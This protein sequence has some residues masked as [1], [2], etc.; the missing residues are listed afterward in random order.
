MILDHSIS[1]PLESPVL[2]VLSLGAG[3][4]SSVLALMAERG[5]L[6]R[7]DA[8]IFA[9]TG[10]EPAK[11]YEWLDWLEGQLSYPVLRVRRPGPGLGALALEVAAGTRPFKGTVLPPFF[12]TS[13][14]G[15]Q[16]PKQC[17]AEFKRDV[18]NRE[19]RRLL[20]ERGIDFP[21]GVMVEQWLGMT[22]DELQRIKD[23]RRK[24]IFNRWPL[25]EMRMKRRDC[26]PWMEERQYPRPPKS[27]CIYCPYRSNEGFRMMRD[28]APDDFE[29][30]CTFD[31]A[32]RLVLP[33]GEAFVHRSMTPLR[34]VNLDHASDDLFDNECEGVCGV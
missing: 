4:Q 21:K 31:E 16:M 25:V 30:A 27:A 15:G 34:L 29:A 14:G 6:P 1:R 33:A 18:V 5:D 8:A 2:R 26:F 9:D 23:N 28:E 19:I 3:V 20:G 32:I 12:A 13:N 7:L 24:Y 17:N 11:V 22:T 10:D